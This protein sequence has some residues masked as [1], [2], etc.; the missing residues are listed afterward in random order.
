MKYKM[1]KLMIISIRKYH[2]IYNSLQLY[3]KNKINYKRTKTILISLYW[4][5]RKNKDKKNNKS[6][7]GIVGG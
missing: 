2:I 1:I 3:E 5:I 4:S 7:F 6:F